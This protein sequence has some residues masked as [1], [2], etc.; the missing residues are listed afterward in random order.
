MSNSVQIRIDAQNNAS[1][2]IAKVGNS[3]N[4]LDSSL[5][6]TSQQTTSLAQ[7][8]QMLTTETA[9]TVPP[10]NSSEQAQLANILAS[11][12][13]KTAQELLNN[14]NQNLNRTIK[15][16]GAD[17]KEAAQALRDVNTAQATVKDMQTQLGV[18]TQ[19][20]SFNMKELTVSLSGVATSAFSLYSAYD[21]VQDMQVAVDRANLQVSTSANSLTK[22]DRRLYQLR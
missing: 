19:Q 18:S 3:L 5:R 22:V 16:Y 20:T 10:L 13:L 7:S 8:M 2:E 9:S 12:Q 14:A 15:E 21:R 4:G 6:Q 1:P 17:S 11:Q